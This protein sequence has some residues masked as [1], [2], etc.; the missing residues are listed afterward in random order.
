MAKNP[1]RR[2]TEEEIEALF[3]EAMEPSFK[4]GL[5]LIG[6]DNRLDLYKGIVL[7]WSTDK[8]R[9]RAATDLTERGIQSLEHGW[10]IYECEVSHD[11]CITLTNYKPIK[12]SDS[13]KNRV[14]TPAFKNCRL[15]MIGGIGGGCRKLNINF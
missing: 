15:T 7:G 10:I 2:L 8:K 13:L 9:N 5:I 12:Y 4:K 14:N 11:G 6:L 1:R 3:E